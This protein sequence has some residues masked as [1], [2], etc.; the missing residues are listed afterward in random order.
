MHTRSID[1]NCT[2]KSVQ[3]GCS[4]AARPA[5]YPKGID[6]AALIRKSDVAATTIDDMNNARRA[7]ISAPTRTL[8]GA[9]A[10]RA[11]RRGHGS[12]T[13]AQ[14][15]AR[16]DRQSRYCG[17]PHRARD[18]PRAT[19]A[20]QSRPRQ[21][22]DVEARPDV[23]ETRAGYRWPALLALDREMDGPAPRPR[24]DR[25]HPC[26]R[27]KGELRCLARATEDPQSR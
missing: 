5:A 19:A 12:C 23:P 11:R 4:S 8:A 21:D 10:S 7:F 18:H 15:P 9:D 22:G 20:R 3:Y 25:N 24:Y 6:T 2:E 14:A 26:R 17:L 27:W 16:I 13:R 1:E